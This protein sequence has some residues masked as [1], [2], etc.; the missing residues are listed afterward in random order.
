M[1]EWFNIPYILPFIMYSPHKMYFFQ[2][3]LLLFFTLQTLFKL[4]ILSSAEADQRIQIH[5]SSDTKQTEQT[6]P[7]E[8]RFPSRL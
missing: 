5:H 4:K 2:N 3:G 7:I 1:I 8:G 6:D